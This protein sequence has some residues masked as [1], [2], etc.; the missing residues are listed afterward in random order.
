MRS[1]NSHRHDPHQH[2]LYKVSLP[3][4]IIDIWAN[5][6]NLDLVHPNQKTIEIAERLIEYSSNEGNIVLDP[7]LGSGTTAIACEKLRR[8]WIGIE[9]DSRYC[10]VAKKRLETWRGQARLDVL[11]V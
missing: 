1:A 6:F 4:L 9:I 3:S 5:E 11:N 8:R 2:N 7:F 10:D